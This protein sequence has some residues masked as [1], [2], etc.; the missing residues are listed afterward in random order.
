MNKSIFYLNVCV[1]KSILAV[2][3]HNNYFKGFFPEINMIVGCTGL[4]ASGKDEV[5]RILQEMNFF[6]ISLSDFIR[7]EAKSRELSPSRDNLIKVG[8]ELRTDFGADVLA[9][10]AVMK[11]NDGENYVITSIRNPFEVKAL[12]RRDDFLLINVI[13]QD[14]M[15]VKRI[16]SRGREGDP[17]TL[18][19]LKA[20]ERKENSSNPN[21]QQLDA[22][23]KM[24]KVTISNNSTLDVLEKKVGK[25]VKDWLF[26]LQDSRPDWDSY[27]MN[28]AEQVKMRATCMSAKKGAIVVRNKM[29]VSTGYNGSPK[30]IVHCTDGGCERCTLRHLGKLKSGDYSAPCICCHSEENAIVQAAVNGVSTRDAVMYTTFTPCTNCAKLII[31]AGIKK[32]VAMVNYPDDVGHKLLRDAGVELVVKGK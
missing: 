26:K 17:K 24:A 15:R 32:V 16:V 13:A 11:L 29:I 7:E 6:H 4:N 22:V 12:D 19:E 27:F 2:L 20:K 18:E 1:S 3:Q 30:N 5:A 23:A 21:A 9:K 25:L 8:N 14:E 28:I 31:N 10:R